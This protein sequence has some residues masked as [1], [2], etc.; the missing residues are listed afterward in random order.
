ML[1][2]LELKQTNKRP[3]N[4]SFNVSN[5]EFALVNLEFLD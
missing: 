2:T 1:L 3:T 5:M 4:I